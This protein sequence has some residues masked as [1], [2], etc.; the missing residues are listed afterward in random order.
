[1][2]TRGATAAAFIVSSVL[3]L[4]FGWVTTASPQAPAVQRGYAPVNGLKMY[5]ELHGSANGRTPPLVLLHGGGS[6]IE[7]SFGGTLGRLATTRQVIA[8]DQQGHGHTADIVDRPFTFEQSAEDAVALL[9]YLKIGKADFF[10]YSN[11]GQIAIQIA[12]GHADIVRKLVVMSAMFSREGCD[13]GFWESFKHPKLDEMPADLREAY[14]HV[15]PRPEELP[16]LFA[17]SVQRMLNFKGWS[18]DEI[19]SI[20]AP[21]LVMIGDHDIVRPEHAVLMF[22]LLPNSNLAVLPDTDHMRV[23]NRSDWLVSMIGAFLDSPMPKSR[24]KR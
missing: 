10:G 23:V 1:V 12:L 19:R 13:P 11:G 6:T 24:E 5:Y 8:F 3:A 15:A 21:T 16:S 22:R 17:K 4:G 7:T 9:R 18:Q 14:L 20:A 2:T